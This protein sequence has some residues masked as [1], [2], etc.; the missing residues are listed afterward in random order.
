M[1]KY[2]FLISTGLFGSCS[3]K[4]QFRSDQ[5][6]PI[7]AWLGPPE[8]HANIERYT[9]LSEAGFNYNLST[10]SS[11]DQV[12]KVLEVATHSGVKVFIRCPELK[13]DPKMVAKKF[14]SHPGLAGY[15]L[16]DE[17]SAKQFDELA[18]WA[19]VIQ[20]VDSI[21]PTYINLFP[22]YASIDQLGTKTYSSHIK[23]FIDKVP[24]QFLSFDHYPILKDGIRSSWYKDLEI[25]SRESIIAGM[26]FWSF[27]L[28]VAHGPY[29]VAELEHL[30][31]QV[32]SNLAYGT[33]GIQYFTYWTPRDSR[34][35]FNTGPINH[36]GSQSIVYDRVKQ[37][38]REVQELAPIFLDAQV[39][40][41]AHLGDSLPERTRSY[42]SKSPVLSIST[43]GKGAIV[44]KLEKEGMEILAIVNRSFKKEITLEIRFDGSRKVHYMG[45]SAFGEL[46]RQKSDKRIIL[47]G[48]ITIY[49]WK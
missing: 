12:A 33:Q 49:T 26:P 23:E 37:V 27:A 24:S 45:K 9:E 32:F 48:D 11:I 17:P 10:S 3:S 36:D 38:N 47:P 18:E 13:K 46:I 44:S 6:F 21:H 25:V 4:I 35:N 41:I 30:R 40:S 8:P 1:Y 16:Q 29:P 5:Q 14:M 20:A 42:K 31:L 39:I 34:Y 19:K 2:I 15:Y 28:T 7:V 22:S 43:G